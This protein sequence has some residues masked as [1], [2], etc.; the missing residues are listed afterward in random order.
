MVGAGSDAAPAQPHIVRAGAL[1]QPARFL[2]PG[3]TVLGRRA[4]ADL[5]FDEEGVSRLHARL[6]VGNGREV[7]LV[8]LGSKNGTWLNGSRISASS[9][10]HG[11][12][13]AF[14]VVELELVFLREREERRE[15]S[16]E[17]AAAL[18]RLD[19]SPR[20]WEV[21]KLV[22]TGATNVKIA[23]ALFISP[24]TVSTH[25]ERIYGRLEIHSRAELAALVTARQQRR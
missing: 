7:Q 24:S 21:A 18:P 19:L 10:H 1:D 20:E 4:P 11:D 2:Q 15:G 25:L 14:G 12:L 17:S 22:A 9:V 13:I 23:G 16:V 8:D 5:V 6:I 3:P